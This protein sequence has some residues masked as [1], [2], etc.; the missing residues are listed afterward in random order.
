MVYEFK[1]PDIGEGV[2][3][4]EIV[5]WLVAE[6]DVVAEDQ[7][8]VEV[9]TDK[10]TVEIPSPRAGTIAKLGAAQGAIVPVGQVLVV[11]AV[12]GEAEAGAPVAALV[13]AAYAATAPVATAA[14]PA[15]PIKVEAVP[16][17]RVLATERGLDLATVSGTGPGGRITV[18]DVKRALEGGGG[19]AAPETPASGGAEERVPLRGLRRRIAEHMV[20]AART[21]PQFTFVA[22]ADMS[23][24]VAAREKAKAGGAKETYLAWIV[25]AVVASLR[26]FPLLNASLDEAAGEIVL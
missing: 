11:I 12:A 15:A 3:E 6:G 2:A 8:L 9:L 16:A 21:V 13:P 7:P 4:A 20:H 19:N 26:E 1:L 18:D 17:A 22:E 25:R 23:A 5:Q 14:S 10:A 24:V